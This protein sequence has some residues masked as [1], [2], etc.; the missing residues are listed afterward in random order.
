M[1]DDIPT[2]NEIHN[3]LW[4]K[5]NETRERYGKNLTPEN[6]DAYRQALT[7]LGDWAMRRE[8]PDDSE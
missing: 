3:A 1:A 7:A 8:L 4:A 2:P 6:R 5:V